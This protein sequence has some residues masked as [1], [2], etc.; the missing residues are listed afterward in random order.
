VDG[1]GKDIVFSGCMFEVEICHSP[2]GGG[3]FCLLS[4]VDTISTFVEDV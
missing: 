3:S 1:T 2:E 4:E